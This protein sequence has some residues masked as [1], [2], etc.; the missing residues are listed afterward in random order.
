MVKLGGEAYRLNTAAYK[1]AFCLALT[2]GSRQHSVCASRQGW[3]VK[4]TD[5]GKEDAH[6]FGVGV[7]RRERVC[8]DMRQ[9]PS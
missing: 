8:A 3:P 2:Q 1:N 6:A 7:G 9:S 5:P 4:E